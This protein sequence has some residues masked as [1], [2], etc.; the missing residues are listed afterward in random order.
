MR[1]RTPLVVAALLALPL[2]LAWRAEPP[3]TAQK[4]LASR[5]GDRLVYF[6]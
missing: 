2:F 6:L 5:L 3:S 4:R 1:A